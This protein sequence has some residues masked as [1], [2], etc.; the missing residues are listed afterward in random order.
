MGLNAGR[1]KHSPEKGS[2]SYKIFRERLFRIEQAAKYAT[3]GPWHYDSG[4]GTIE[5]EHPMHSRIEVVH[6][7]GLLERI[8][9]AKQNGLPDIPGEIPCDPSADMSYLSELDPQTVLTMLT[10]I[11]TAYG[12]LRRNL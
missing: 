5:S 3:P 4:N 1:Y 8:A 12:G 7:D 9:W 2:M 11:H 6:R 10:L